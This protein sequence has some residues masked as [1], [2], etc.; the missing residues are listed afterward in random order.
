MT[1]PKEAFKKNPRVP[2]KFAS[3][4]RGISPVCGGEKVSPESVVRAHDWSTTARGDSTGRE[5]CWTDSP[6]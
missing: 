5:A 6:R 3:D 2:C 1:N 4:F